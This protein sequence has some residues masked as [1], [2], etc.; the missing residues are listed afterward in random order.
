MA[1]RSH[2]ESPWQFCGRCGR[3]SHLNKMVRQ[4][5]ILICSRASCLDKELVGERDL[6]IAK[7]LTAISNSNEG[8]P[9]KRLTE[10]APSSQG[11]DI[12]F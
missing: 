9:D 2:F 11:D 8:L 7:K 5:G 3:K 4:R 12:I 1:R 6:A 10:V